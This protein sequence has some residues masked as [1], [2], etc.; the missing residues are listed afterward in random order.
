MLSA[1]TITD[2]SSAWLTAALRPIDAA[3]LA[4]FRIGFGLLM[5]WWATDYLLTGRVRDLYVVPTFH[6]TY[7]PFAFVRPW[8]GVGMMWHF[9]GLAL[10]GLAI[11]AGLWYRLASTLF[12]VG[13]LYVFLVERTNYQNHYYLI[14]LISGCLPLLPLN[15]LWAMDAADGRVVASET[16]PAWCLWVARAHLAVP[17]FYG[18]IAKLHPDWFAGEP[19]R[20]HLALSTWVPVV[21]PYLTQEWLVQGFIWGGLLFDLLIVPLL[22]WRPTRWAAYGLC[23]VFHLTNAV[24]FHIHVFPWFMLFATLLF[25]EPDWPR[26]LLRQSPITIPVGQTATW[27]SLSTLQRWTVVGAMLY[28]GFHLV[29]PLRHYAYPGDAAW[30]EQ[31][32]WFAWRMMLRA[33]TSAVR[34]YMTDAATGVTWV[35][36]LRPYLSGDQVGKF[37]RSPEMILQL[38]QHL[39]GEYRRET[40]REAEVRALVL[41]SLN[42]R[43]PQLLI[44]PQVDLAREPRGFQ[45]RPWIMP[46]TEPLRTPAWSEPL[47]E[48]ERLVELPPLPVVTMPT[49]TR[50]ATPTSV[51]GNPPQ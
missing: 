26:R 25:F 23:A 21:G 38:A 50:M 44:D 51:A 24:L 30:T 1:S 7:E 39:A 32:H 37:G 18:G 22:L 15:R 27:T 41:T 9:A 36:D 28:G 34:Y 4:V 2:R 13:F 17:Y 12:A 11:A 16:V 40:G 14:C 8:P 49:T 48:W 43:K 20:A 19:M 45:P 35:P 47:T 5:A 10:L 6:F 29:W 42:G 46:L 31:G 3:S 33:K